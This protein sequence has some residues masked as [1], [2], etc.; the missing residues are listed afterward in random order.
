MDPKL[1][2]LKE[3]PMDEEESDLKELLRQNIESNKLLRSSQQKED[4]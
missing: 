2:P 3:E 4:L 1:T